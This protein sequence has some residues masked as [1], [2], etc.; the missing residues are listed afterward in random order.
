MAK[1]HPKLFCKFSRYHVT[2]NSNCVWREEE[3]FHEPG[4]SNHIVCREKHK[5]YT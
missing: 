2:F 3:K 1:N 5:R 4:K